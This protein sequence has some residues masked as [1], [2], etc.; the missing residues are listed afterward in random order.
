MNGTHLS[1]NSSGNDNDLC[2]SESV[3]QSII[4]L[5]VTFGNGRRIYV[6]DIGGDSLDERD[7]IEQG[8]I[9][10]EVVLQ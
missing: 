4:F 9:R 3:F 8:E 6:T 5:G 7:N 2:T 10:D 1:G